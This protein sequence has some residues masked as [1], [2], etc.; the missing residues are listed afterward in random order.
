[1]FAARPIMSLCS[2]FGCCSRT[3]LCTQ[4]GSTQPG[5][6]SPALATSTNSKMM[7]DFC[8]IFNS[9]RHMF[10]T[11]RCLERAFAM[12]TARPGSSSPALH[13]LKL[14]CLTRVAC[15]SESDY[16]VNWLPGGGYNVDECVRAKLHSFTSS[17]V[18]RDSQKRFSIRHLPITAVARRVSSHN[19]Q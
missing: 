19:S 4:P 16:A 3:L 7:T 13:Q 12:R 10:A 2:T 9:R 11:W 15:P 17:H 18:S 14:W 8:I 6:Y 5:C 1:M